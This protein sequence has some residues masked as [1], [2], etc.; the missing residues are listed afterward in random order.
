MQPYFMGVDYADRIDSHRI[1]SQR[2][3][4]ARNYYDEQVRRYQELMVQQVALQPPQPIIL[5]AQQNRR[6]DV[7]VNNNV[8]DWADIG[9]LYAANYGSN[10][11]PPPKPEA[12]EPPKVE[13][14]P[15]RKILSAISTLEL[16][17]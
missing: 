17:E 3:Q 14:I 7:S 11:Q 1:Y 16:G 2:R 8:Y 13:P 9:R 5:T 10:G 4:D 6:S 15:P 12:K